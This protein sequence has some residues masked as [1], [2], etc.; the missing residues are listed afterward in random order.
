M[1]LPVTLMLAERPTVVVF[2]IAVA[3]KL[4][5]FVPDDVLNVSHE[6][7]SDVDHVILLE[8]VID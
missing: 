2:A 8:T 3:V 1:P 7:S 5:L 4:P 6:A